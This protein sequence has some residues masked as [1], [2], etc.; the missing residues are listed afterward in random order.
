MFTLNISVPGECYLA[1]IDGRWSIRSTTE[2]QVR[3]T[4]QVPILREARISRSPQGTPWRELD[5]NKTSLIRIWRQHPRYSKEPTSS[6]I[7]LL[8][9]C[10]ELRAL[11]QMIR[12]I[13]R[14]RMNAGVLFI[15]D[16][17]RVAGASVDKDIEATE[18]ETE[19]LIDELFDAVVNPI[20]NE[21]A[22]TSAVPVFITGP[23]DLGEKIKWI[24]FARESDRYLIQRAE[25]ILVRILNGL[26]MPK[27]K[28]EGLSNVRY[29]NATVVDD[30]LYRLHIEPLAVMLCDAVTTS[31]LRGRL[32]KKFPNLNPETLARLVFWYDPSEIVTKADPA[33]SANEGY[34]REL[35]SGD[36][37]RRAHGFSDADAPSQTEVAM[38]MVLDQVGKNLSP[39]AQ[40]H[41]LQQVLPELFGQ[42]TS[43]GSPLPAKTL[44]QDAT[45]GPGDAVSTAGT[46]GSG[47]T[48]Q[49]V[50]PTT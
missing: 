9:L 13:A 14:S 37:W 28:V 40:A 19:E 4:D 7:A 1:L 45:Y 29:T 18:D 16:G 2:L 3:L 31:Y 39:E 34:D 26:N 48:E 23:E 6:M 25:D 44:P 38:R 10:Q 11:Q 49:I 15:P 50:E 12:G 30:D 21:T 20:T 42:K 41:I 5:K 43:A 8:E 22:A 47:P 46:N 33:E 32:K 35:I 36:S 17:L 27:E 24:S